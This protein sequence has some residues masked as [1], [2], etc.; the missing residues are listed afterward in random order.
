MSTAYEYDALHR[1]IARVLASGTSLER[2]STLSYDAA[3]NIILKSH[4]NGLRELF[5][6][7]GVNRLARIDY[8]RNHLVDK[9]ALVPGATYE[10]F[11]HDGL[12]RLS[13][14]ENDT[15]QVD[16]K[17]DSFGRSTEESQSLN[18]SS[19][20]IRRSFDVLGNRTQLEYPS[21]R[22]IRFSYDLASRLNGIDDTKR[23]KPNVGV[24]GAG[25]RRILDRTFVGMRR[26]SDTYSNGLS[27]TYSY[28]ASARC[29]SINHLGLAGAPLLNL[30]YLYDASGDRRHDWQSGSEAT[31]PS[32]AYSYDG[33]HRLT[34]V[35]DT[36]AKLPNIQTFKPPAIPRNPLVGQAGVDAALKPSAIATA[37]R[38]FNYVYDA[39]SNRTRETVSGSTTPI[40]LLDEVASNQ[41]YDYDGNPI[42]IGARTLS[43]DQASRLVDVRGGATAFSATYDALGRRLE[44]Q[45]GATTTRFVYD[46]P[47]EIAEYQGGQLFSEHVVSAPPDDR[48]QL[49]TGGHEYIVHRDLVGSSRLLTDESGQR[50]A[51][52]DFNPYGEV[53]HRKI[54]PALPQAFSRHRFMGREWDSSIGLYHF[55]ARHYD[56]TLGRFLQRDPVDNVLQRSAYQAFD[57]NPLM[58][59]DP[60]GTNP[61]DVGA[62][63]P[64]TSGVAVD[65]GI[66][67]TDYRLKLQPYNWVHQTI[68]FAAESAQGIEESSSNFALFRYHKEQFDRLS[69]VLGRSVS[70]LNMAMSATAGYLAEGIDDLLNPMARAS[71]W[72]DPNGYLSLAAQELAQTTPWK[73]DDVL[74][75][76]FR[77]LQ[78][79]FASEVLLDTSAVYKFNRARL[80]LREIPV[81]SQA[82]L[83]ELEN[84]AARG[85]RAM[86]SYLNLFKVVPDEGTVATRLAIRQGIIDPYLIKG[87]A[88]EATKNNPGIR[89]FWADGIIGA[90]ALKSNRLLITGDSAFYEAFTAMGGDARFVK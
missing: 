31:T 68:D 2:R 64:S 1:R 54:S 14:A 26:A 71:N 30:V 36:A 63:G 41:T 3:G 15:S 90:T 25:V 83:R 87:A 81:I 67:I 12:G 9:N 27:T 43:Y 61:K 72:V 76:G 53:T 69:S 74:A 47:S 60:F 80:E 34:Q 28:D 57:S 20:T 46:G 38:D 70:F 82:V 51:L 86:P 4:A 8:D 35:G 32:R 16:T 66:S 75:Y 49:T 58:F 77:S 18:G 88:L 33:M 40:D 7:D 19:I 79:R 85:G 55:R 52:F 84:N 21:G 37:K 6:Y 56:P 10:S 45:E 62:T 50:R 65:F 29:I 5:Q 44:I 78:L 24:T 22:K 23:G 13:H 89:G 17:F 11:M 39:G 48:V 42:A 73:L 59:I